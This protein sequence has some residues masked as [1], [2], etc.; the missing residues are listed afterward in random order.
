MARWLVLSPFKEK[1][2]GI[3]FACLSSLLYSLGTVSQIWFFGGSYTQTK[4]V[5]LWEWHRSPQVQS[6]LPDIAI[7]V[8]LPFLSS[9]R[10]P[11]HQQQSV[12]IHFPPRLGPCVPGIT[13]EKWRHCHRIAVHNYTPMCGHITFVSYVLHWGDISFSFFSSELVIFFLLYCN[14]TQKGWGKRMIHRSLSPFS[15]QGMK[16]R[17]LHVNHA[18]WH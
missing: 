2:F 15:H 9:S 11:R 8:L 13:K 16:E 5:V 14:G 12:S 6:G 1:L 10:I 4:L 3:N 7:K 17:E 18:K